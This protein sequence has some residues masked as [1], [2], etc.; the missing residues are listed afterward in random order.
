[1]LKKNSDTKKTRKKKPI[2]PISSIE[3][4]PVVDNTSEDEGWLMV[5]L[6]V[7][8]LLLIMFVVMLS[9]SG[10]P[11]ND[12]QD[13]D[14]AN[15]VSV[16][17]EPE[18]EPEDS[19]SDNM[20]KDLGNGDLGGSIDVIKR[21]NGVSFRISND[22]LF[23]SGKSELADKGLVE[24][25]KLV[26]FLS[27]TDYKVTVA[28]H[29]DNVPISTDKFPSNWELSSARAGSVVR[30]FQAQG[31][32]PDRLVARGHADT[33]PLVANTTAQ[34]RAKNRRVELVLEDVSDTSED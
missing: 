10:G 4:T 22:V 6:D 29:T 7:I 28:G 8:T 24:L 27:R 18:P 5:Y 13:F 17:N 12:P 11:A 9:Q 19:K 34:N 23:S 30:F 16:H 25:G 14:K 2:K 32:Q 21:K 31:I 3:L 20:M 26:P 33:N 15:S 1:M